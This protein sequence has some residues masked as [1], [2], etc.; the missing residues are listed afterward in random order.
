MARLE[1]LLFSVVLCLCLFGKSLEAEVPWPEGTYGLPKAKT[2]CPVSLEW[3]TGWRFE[4]TED[5]NPSNQKSLSYHLDAAV[6]TDINRTFCMKVKNSET[7]PWPRGQ[8]CIFKKGDCPKGFREGYVFWDDENNKNINKKGGTLPD[9]IYNQDTLIYYCCRGDGNKLHPVSLPINSPFYLKA[10]NTSDCQRVKG[11]IATEEYIRFDN[12]D[13]RN[14]DRQNGSYPYG[15]GIANHK[16]SYCYYQSCDYT[17]SLGNNE[18]IKFTS[19]N[20]FGEGYPIA[21]RCTWRFIA[22]AK[23]AAHVAFLDVDIEDGDTI[24]IQSGWD[25]G[26]TVGSIEKSKPPNPAGYSPS[27]EPVNLLFMVFQS[28]SS[29]SSRKRS[30][31]FRG[32][33]TVPSQELPPTQ[34]EWPSGTFGLPRSRIGC[35]PSDNITSWSTGWRYHDTEDNNPNNY[36]SS[37]FHMDATILKNDL[38]RSFC[39]ATTNKGSRE[40]P[41]G[42]YCIYKKENCPKGL[43]E[44]YIFFDDENFKNQNEM[45]GTL[46]D[47][48]YN[49]DTKLS[50][51]CRTDGN[52]TAPITL[53]VM[54][55]FYLMAF[56]SSECQQVEGALASKESIRFDNEDTNNKD[57][58]NGTHAYEKEGA[59]L[60]ITYCYYEVCHYTISGKSQEFFSPYYQTDGYPNSQFCTWRF[61]LQQKAKN[62][63]TRKQILLKFP[64]FRLQKGKDGDVMRIYSGWDEKAP[65]LAEFSG[66]NPPPPE[67]VAFNSS[68]AYLV[69]RSDSRGQSQGFHGSFLIQPFNASAVPTRPITLPERPG[70]K[71]ATATNSPT[72]RPATT[73]LPSAAYGKQTTTQSSPVATAVIVPVVIVLIL[74]AAMVTVYYIRRKRMEA[75]VR[76]ALSETHLVSNNDSS[77]HDLNSQE[78]DSGDEL[79]EIFPQG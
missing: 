73:V 1:S 56:N 33:F 46:P 21:Q 65:L 69:F 66:D 41:K 31:G 78:Y 47:G 10:F 62:L 75:R 15:S 34:P 6:G 30:K 26:A 67:G 9:G 74:V 36:K 44:G 11:A 35:P 52:K 53:P 17:Y 18:Q 59:G 54:T 43:T 2:G 71:T 27:S 22:P 64:E 61:L 5:N 12:E 39:I 14:K 25:S 63:Q 28:R 7:T 23:R 20:Y 4:D 77:Y 51:C 3:T 60:T 40:W 79:Q 50:Y 13:V 32:I 8:Y 57:A 19:P 58:F 24:E 16:M 55:P 76:K 45:G 48:V 29:S 37:S 38:N 42:Q 72:T 70:A 49:E 68:V